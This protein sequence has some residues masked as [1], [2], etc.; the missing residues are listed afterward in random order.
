VQ[1]HEYGLIDE[2]LDVLKVESKGKY[3]DVLKRLYIYKTAKYKQIFKEQYAG[4]SNVLFG[5]V[6]GYDKTEK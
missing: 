4:E 1:K 2:T 6:I 3:L 5:L